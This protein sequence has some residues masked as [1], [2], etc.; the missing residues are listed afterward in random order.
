MKVTEM[1]YHRNGVGGLPFHVG[2]VHNDGREMLVVRFTKEADEQTGNV[3]CAAF[4][5]AK[6]DQR[7]IRFFHNSWRGDHYS[8]IMDA[9]IEKETAARELRWEMERAYKDLQ[10]V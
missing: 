5:L 9:A 6:L 4:D 1:H 3:V 10:G 8:G 7:E 2:I